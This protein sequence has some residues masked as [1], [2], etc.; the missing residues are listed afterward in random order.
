MGMRLSIVTPPIAEP[1]GLD[2]MKLFLRVTGTSDDQL[3]RQ[4]IRTARE[5]CERFTER[6]LVSTQY[7][8]TVDFFPVYII[9]GV[10]ALAEYQTLPY[11]SQAGAALA[12]DVDYGVL[13]PADIRKMTLP[14][15]GNFT[16]PRPPLVSVDFV[17]YVDE[18]GVT[19]TL[20]PATYSVVTS[21][22]PGYLKTL[23]G[24]PAV[25]GNTPD[26][27]NVTFTS[28]YPLPENVPEVYKTAIKLM[29]SFYYE[30]RI[31]V[32]GADAAIAQCV[33]RLLFQEKQFSMA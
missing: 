5:Y 10:F 14:N 24:W 22:I 11:N 23:N 30:N 7:R 12:Q 18:D 8:L 26:C 3:I 6:Q 16:L 21:N 2:E 19:Q 9:Q 33:D 20:D 13:T 17:T 1:V 28:G 4:L 27:V 32:A 25:K 15:V 29:A 31:P